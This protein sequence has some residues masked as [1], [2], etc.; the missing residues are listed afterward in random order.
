M[1]ISNINCHSNKYQDTNWSTP[2]AQYPKI[3]SYYAF[4]NRASETFS[5]SCSR[6]HRA[7]TEFMAFPPYISREP[8]RVCLGTIHRRA[9][10]RNK[11]IS[12]LSLSRPSS[13][14]TD[15]RVRPYINARLCPI[16]KAEQTLE[17]RFIFFLSLFLSFSLLLFSIDSRA[18]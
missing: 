7:P 2:T 17:D 13:R 9:N 3:T 5:W 12:S 11:S 6:S 1:L 18:L 16:V 15:T 10:S 14:T 4:P 8:A